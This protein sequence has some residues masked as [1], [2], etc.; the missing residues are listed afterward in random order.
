MCDRV[1]TVI[2]ISGVSTWPF[3]RLVRFGVI[4]NTLLI[5]FFIDNAKI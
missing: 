3:V 5:A 1:V 2:V 4:L